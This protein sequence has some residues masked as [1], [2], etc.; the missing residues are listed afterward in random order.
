MCYVSVLQYVRFVVVPLPLDV[1]VCSLQLCMPSVS[2]SFAADTPWWEPRGCHRGRRRHMSAPCNACHRPRAAL[3]P[4]P[5]R[6]LRTPWSVPASSPSPPVA[7]RPPR[8]PLRK[9][10]PLPNPAAPQLPTQA[11]SRELPL[12]ELVL[13]RRRLGRASSAGARVFLPTSTF[14]PLPS[15]KGIPQRYKWYTASYR[16]N[17]NS[18]SKLPIQTVASGI[19]RYK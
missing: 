14:I 1:D 3:L 15:S 8:L 10:T 16:S 13:V 4:T 17:S 9:A 7:H 18:K 19:P 11:A 2:C 6:G 5:W 12:S